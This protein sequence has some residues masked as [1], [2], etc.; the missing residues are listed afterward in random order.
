MTNSPEASWSCAVARPSICDR[1]LS[2][3]A[4]IW[5]AFNESLASASGRA[6]KE[7]PCDNTSGEGRESTVSSIPGQVVAGYSRK[8]KIAPKRAP[9][10]A[11]IS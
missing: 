4:A 11:Q 10:G 1:A 7:N 8:P 5:F 6:R 9:P 3:P 2:P